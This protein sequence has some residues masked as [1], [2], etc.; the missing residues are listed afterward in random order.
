MTTLQTKLMT[1]DEL[2]NMPKIDGRRFEL[3]RGV[4]V[5]KMP[6]G[7]SQGLVS[8]R[9]DRILGNYAEDNDFGVTLS[10]GIIGNSW[11]GLWVQLGL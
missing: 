3:I 2:L 4:L 11:H 1:A 9:I 8:S 5:E 10:K 7:K 6:S